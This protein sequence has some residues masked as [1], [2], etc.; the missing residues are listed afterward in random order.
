MAR[1][2]S[3]QWWCSF[4]GEQGK[5]ENKSSWWGSPHLP[6]LKVNANY[7]WKAQV[8]DHQIVGKEPIVT[9]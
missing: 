4:E 8:N 2:M 9:R 6:L 1:R 5:F 7:M 3:L